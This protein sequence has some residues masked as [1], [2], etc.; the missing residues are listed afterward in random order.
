MREGDFAR[1]RTASLAD[2]CGHRCCMMGI[3]RLKSFA[4]LFAR[5]SG[6]FQLLMFGE[7]QLNIEICPIC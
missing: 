3:V 1:F 4:I 2:N 7:S 5:I 6:W